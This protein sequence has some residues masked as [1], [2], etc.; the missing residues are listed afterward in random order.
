[1]PSQDKIV[2]SPRRINRLNVE[3][4]SVVG[5]SFSFLCTISVI[6]TPT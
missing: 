1:M 3:S 5:K 2:C 6:I 4:L